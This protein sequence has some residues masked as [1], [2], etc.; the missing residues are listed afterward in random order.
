MQK[1]RRNDKKG[2][3]RCVFAVMQPGLYPLPGPAAAH[4]GR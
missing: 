3:Y 1:P 4:S 2:V